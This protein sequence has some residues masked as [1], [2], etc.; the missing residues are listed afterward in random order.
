MENEMTETAKLNQPAVPNKDQVGL[1]LLRISGA[2]HSFVF[3][4]S[5]T[6]SDVTKH[7]FDNWP[8]EWTEDTVEEHGV[9]RLI[10]QGRFLHGKAT[11]GALKI[12][13]G[14]TTIMHLVSRATVPEPNA[15][16]EI[17]WLWLNF[18]KIDK[19]FIIM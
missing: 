18:K 8:E 7:V 17:N 15:Q 11:L 16:G 9:L 4:P 2:T 5:D 14:K 13:S 19:H 3:L 10:Y 6:I 12:P 1:K